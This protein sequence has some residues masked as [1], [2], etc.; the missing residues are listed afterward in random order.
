M[1]GAPAFSSRARPLNELAK[2]YTQARVEHGG[3]GDWSALRDVLVRA[4]ASSS[5]E[6]LYDLTEDLRMLAA[7]PAATLFI[8]IDQIEELLGA[9]GEA[10]DNFWKLLRMILESHGQG[11]V[12]LGTLRSDYLAEFQMHEQARD[13]AY[14]PFHLKSSQVDFRAVIEGP[15]AI[16][17][18]ELKPGLVDAMAA[19]TGTADALPLLAFTLGELWKRFGA[20]RVLTIDEYRTQLGGLQGSVARAAE[21]V[22]ASADPS[23]ELQAELRKTFVGLTRV[24]ERGRYI[25]KPARWSDQPDAVH[26]ILEQFIQRRLLVSRSV[27]GERVIEAAHDV[28]FTS[29]ERLAEWLQ[30]DEPFLLW[31][32]RL[33]AAV[34]EWLRTDK[35]EG[36]LLRGNPLHEAE[37][38]FTARGSELNADEAALIGSS[39]ELRARERSQAEI[40]EWAARLEAARAFY[41]R[42][43]VF[44]D[45][46]RFQSAAACLLRALE[47][48]PRNGAPSGFPSAWGSPAWA[49][50]AWTQYRHIDAVRAHRRARFS[51]HADAV[52]CV[53]LAAGGELAVSGSL[54]GKVRVLHLGS[55]R[56]LHVLEAGGEPVSTLA[57]APDSR[58]LIAGTWGGKLVGWDLDTGKSW[59]EG[60]VLQKAGVSSVAFGPDGNRIACGSTDGTVVWFDM[61]S[62]QNKVRTSH[63]VA[64]TAVAFSQD[65]KRV[66]SGSSWTSFGGWAGDGSGIVWDVEVDK[67]SALLGQ[68]ESVASIAFSAS[69]HW[70]KGLEDG[71]VQVGTIEGHGRQL[72]ELK[73]HAGSVGCVSLSPDGKT[74]AS[75]SADTTVRVW[76]ME[77]G[78]LLLVLEG[79]REAVL[80]VA[81]SADGEGLISGSGDRSFVVWDIGHAARPVRLAGAG[82]VVDLA[83]DPNAARAVCASKD[84]LQLWHVERRELVRQFESCPDVVTAVALTPDARTVVTGCESGKVFLWDG[85]SGQKAGLLAGHE[86]TVWA[87]AFSPDGR[88]ILTASEDTTLR[89]WDVESAAQLGVFNGHA[90]AVLA[91]GFSADGRTILSASD[92][93]TLLLWDAQSGKVLRTFSGHRDGVTSVVIGPDG[94]TAISGALDATVRVWDLATGKNT[95]VLKGHEAGVT[96]VALSPDG[97]VAFSASLDRTVRS[98]ST[99]TGKLLQVFAGHEDAVRGLAVTPDGRRLLSAAMDAT[100]RVWDTASGGEIGVLRGH[101]SGVT[102]VVASGDGRLALTGSADKSA[103]LWDLEDQ[104]TVRV[105]QNGHTGDVRSVRWQTDGTTVISSGEDRTIRLWDAETGNQLGAWHGHAKPV[106]CLAI[107]SDGATLLSGD[108]KRKLLDGLG[109]DRNGADDEPGHGAIAMW[110]ARKGN[111][112][113]LNG[114]AGAIWCIAF[115][116]DG[117][118][119]ASGSW[120]GAVRLSDA[121][122][123]K[124]LRLF[125]GHSQ[126][127]VSVAFTPDGTGLLSGSLDR[128]VR[129]WDVETATQ[130]TAFTA[131]TG[132]VGSLALS[133][134]G[135]TAFSASADT[136][137][138]I[139]DVATGVELGRL[140]GHTG[141]VTSVAISR[142]GSVAVTG[143]HDRSVIV[144]DVATAAPVAHLGHE[145]AVYGVAVTA[146]GRTALSVSGDKTLRVW[147]LPK[148]TLARGL[149]GH[150][151]GLTSVALGPDG[152]T[153]L[154]ASDDRTIRV[155][156]LERGS[157]VRVLECD[158]PQASA[159]FSP[160]GTRIASGGADES[161]RVWSVERAT[162]DLVIGSPLPDV[163]ALAIGLANLLAFAGLG[164]GTIG[165][166]RL[167]T[168]A[169]LGR[170]RG[171]TAAVTCIAAQPDAA[172]VLSGSADRTVRVWD[173]ET[174]RQLR[175]L[176][177]H[178]D[179]V[180]S[181]EFGLDAAT[182]ISAS[183]D[184]TVR[185]WDIE[186]GKQLR[187]LKSSDKRSVTMAAKS[188]GGALLEIK[189]PSLGIT[190]AVVDAP[191]RS[192]VA[193]SWDDQAVFIWQ[194]T[195]ERTPAA[196]PVVGPDTDDPYREFAPLYA[197]VGLQV[198]RAGPDQGDIEVVV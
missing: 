191:R 195:H 128:S 2:A 167:D 137:V 18:I 100:C 76:D 152:K 92:D 11:V 110:D 140:A 67:E 109:F 194:A 79:H 93:K 19:D 123:G 59:M 81:F 115:S 16:A 124:Q 64:V 144:W 96:H 6:A 185:I 197:S 45:Q 50:A 175:L 13:V 166:W 120:D 113:L 54:D 31:R 147:E 61:S 7:R 24:D 15:A 108:G 129:V 48:A 122:S 97:A 37:S 142:D 1:A 94:R 99:E 101:R 169:D 25:K 38:W 188:P 157:V 145:D 95:R 23:V 105:F 65:G 119:I 154:S 193:G 163:H 33:H 151:A 14:E 159:V 139:W 126:A 22:Y 5:G 117:T 43:F 181:I 171:H 141:P 77:T 84:T 86:S 103:R 190:R 34:E 91:A 149:T 17:G 173:L 198:V 186:T 158:K 58:R 12:L 29:W 104:G 39:I 150:E 51:G 30:E 55:G 98:W 133:C 63:T 56:L 114:H 90:K 196:P 87:A 161:V 44:S 148:G 27:D 107:S 82:S 187:S 155:W 165:M 78:D 68:L 176:K 80:G 71:T 8:T 143:S 89:L 189:L 75:G 73:G 160:D 130:L 47:L 10:R 170:L 102:S 192:I 168:G 57:V 72:R 40:R 178:S 112:V 134:D 28:L 183:V 135:T 9:T 172:L 125:R 180:T 177:G 174:G 85:R 53:A 74:C 127:V 42:S 20:D 46:G 162:E 60:S 35:D 131:H 153:A 26:G 83:L 88:A 106:S 4:L 70:A 184:G 3:S 179:R 182:A 136:T 111:P 69:G 118:T 156:D 32:R 21:E 138:S 52:T 132:G 121:A 41:E 62:R 116:P 49:R 36:T 146:D 66:L 164:D